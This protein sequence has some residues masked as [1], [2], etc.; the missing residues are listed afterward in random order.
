[1]NPFDDPFERMRREALR[2]R[3]LVGATKSVTGG[4]SLT[5]AE[6]ARQQQALTTVQRDAG[7]TLGVVQEAQRAYHAFNAQLAGSSIGSA[8]NIWANFGQANY[9][10]MPLDHALKLQATADQARAVATKDLALSLRDR[11]LFMEAQRNARWAVGLTDHSAEI[12]R[13]IG[14]NGAKDLA[15]TLHTAKA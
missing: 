12:D 7:L 3:A 2:V 8:P 6:V 10:G 1:M 9:P 4:L 13:L 15:E 5:L 11:D 14:A